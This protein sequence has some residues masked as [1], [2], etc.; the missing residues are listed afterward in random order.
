MASL[1]GLGALGK[2]AV[3]RVHH[4]MRLLVQ[5]FSN[6]GEKFFHVFRHEVAHVCDAEG[7]ILQ[8]AIAIG[9]RQALRGEK[10]IQR[11]HVG[12]ARVGNCRHS[13]RAIAVFR[14]QAIAHF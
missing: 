12:V 4:A 9:E 6:G 13:G 3:L 2:D 1:R 8:L 7:I 11:L 5:E 14:E 10:L